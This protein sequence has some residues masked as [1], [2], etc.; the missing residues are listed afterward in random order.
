MSTHSLFRRSPF[1]LTASPEIAACWAGRSDAQARLSRLLK[2]FGSREDSSLDLVWANLGAG[3]SHLLYHLAHRLREAN[4]GLHAVPVV[5]EIPERIASF[6]D[7]FRAIIAGLPIDDICRWA[8]EPLPIHIPPDLAAAA[9]GLALGGA[10][11]KAVAKQWML[12]ERPDLRDLRRSLAITSRIEDDGHALA[13]LA[14]LCAVCS[15]KGVRMVLMLDEFQRVSQLK[16]RVR[17]GVLSTLRSL[18]SS[19]PSHFSVILAVASRVEASAVQL[20]PP[21]LKTLIGGRPSITLPTFDESEAVQFVLDRFRF[22]RPD[23][24]AGSA[25]A[26]FC[27][28]AIASAVHAL[29]TTHGRPLIPR[30]L[31]QALSWIYDDAFD[32]DC[33]TAAECL[34]SLST[35]RWEQ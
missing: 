1:G 23:G 35:M 24:Y 10:S 31:L 4:S 5:I 21:E 19:T 20:L 16:P 13:V 30:E 25:S 33:I 2:S 18:F 11:E 27:E 12:A 32:G 7:L 26:P 14:G 15:A 22:F 9:R 29:A 17:E 3:K 8:V 28:N 34:K 6:L